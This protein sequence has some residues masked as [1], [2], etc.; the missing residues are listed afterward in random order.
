MTH[1]LVISYQYV[2]QISLLAADF[3]GTFRFFIGNE[4]LTYDPFIPLCCGIIDFDSLEI[5]R[6]EVASLGK[7]FF[8]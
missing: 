6:M 5:I 7:D 4:I 1:L 8:V 3:N 2:A